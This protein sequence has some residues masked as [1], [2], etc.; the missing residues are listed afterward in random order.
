M[1]A[2]LELEDHQP[3]CAGMLGQRQRV[4]IDRGASRELKHPAVLEVEEEH[5]RA[6]VRDQVADR[7]APSA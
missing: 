3:T 1:L 7:Q 6:N 4:P 2:R 5:A